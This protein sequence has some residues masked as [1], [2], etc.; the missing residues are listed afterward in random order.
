MKGHSLVVCGCRAFGATGLVQRASAPGKR[1]NRRLSA[2]VVLRCATNRSDFIETVTAGSFHPAGIALAKITVPASL[3][4]DGPAGDVR[5][6]VPG[7]AGR[8]MRLERPTLERPTA[9]LAPVIESVIEPAPERA[10][11][12]PPRRRETA[13]TPDVASCP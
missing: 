7:S 8:T 13:P 12:P 5:F 9:V 11:A 6:D 10:V 3:G 4:F 2:R 1:S